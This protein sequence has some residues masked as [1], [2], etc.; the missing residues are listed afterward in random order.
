M[1]CQHFRENHPSCTECNRNPILNASEKKSKYTLNNPQ[2]REVCKIKVDS[3]VT[4][5]VEENKCDYLVISCETST[6]FFIEL[7]GSDLLH[8]IDQVDKSIDRLSA[9]LVGFALN[10]RIVL[11]RVQTPDIRTP[12]YKKFHQK[13]RQLGGTFEHKNLVLVETLR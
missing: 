12:K 9:N 4:T 6:A 1:S 13:I 5:S 10:A 7:K 11:T 3:C 2:R 8:A